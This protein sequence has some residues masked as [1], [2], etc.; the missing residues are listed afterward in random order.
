M[1]YLHENTVKFNNNLIDS[2]NDSQL[3]SNYGTALMNELTD[4][5][6]FTQTSEEM[7]TFNDK[8]NYY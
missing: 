3:S 5:F 1:T 4:A 2:H 7:L 6:H 8:R